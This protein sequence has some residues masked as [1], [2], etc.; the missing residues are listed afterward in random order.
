MAGR[1]SN[2]HGFFLEAG[3]NLAGYRHEAG[4]YNTQPNL[5]FGDNLLASDNRG[6]YWRVDRSISRLSWGGGLDYEQYNPSREPGRYSSRQTGV[7]GNAQYRIDRHSSL[8][9]SANLTQLRYQAATQAGGN[10]A[11]MRTVYAS[12]FYQTRFNDWAPTRF[13]ATLRRNQALVVNDVAATGEPVQLKR[14]GTFGYVPADVATSLSLVL[15]ELCQNAIEHGL[16]Q[17][18]GVVQQAGADVDRIRALAANGDGA[19]GCVHAGNSG[20]CHCADRRTTSCAVASAGERVSVSRVR[21]ATHSFSARA[22]RRRSWTSPVVAARAVS[23][24]SRR[25]PASMNSFDQV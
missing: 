10:D 21:S 23:P 6:V 22:S 8:G 11:G 13:R 15:T 5:R 19:G 4:V 20:F 24:A 17:Q 14:E 2:A 1:N 7:H 9:I 25:L 16:G 18:R 12:S 3:A